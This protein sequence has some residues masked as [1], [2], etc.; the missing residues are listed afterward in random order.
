MRK[1]IAANG[2]D[3]DD[4][5]SRVV[6]LRAQ[7]YC[8]R[9]FCRIKFIM[10]MM[11]YLASEKP[12]PLVTWDKENP[13]F[14]VKELDEQAKVVRKQFSQ[15]H[16]Y[17]LGSHQGCGCGFSYGQYDYGEAEER[18]AHE[19][20]RR[21]SEYLSQAIHIAGPLELYSCWDGDQEAEPEFQESIT[22]KEIGGEAFWFQ[23]RQFTKITN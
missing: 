23:E 19:S 14:H 15:T 21:L 17:Y 9:K 22:P 6:V 3:S 8:P 1:M 4:N 20:V 12:L 11:L 18:A 2:A 13:K 7:R 16:V 10:C 5:D